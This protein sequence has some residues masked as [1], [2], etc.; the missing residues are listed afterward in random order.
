MASND[1][2][3][4]FEVCIYKKDGVPYEEFIEWVTKAY[5][6]QVIPLMKKHGI[7]R[8]TQV[9]NKQTTLAT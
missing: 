4:R 8:W 7:T 5:P 6:P 9:N 3:I 2:L 1:N